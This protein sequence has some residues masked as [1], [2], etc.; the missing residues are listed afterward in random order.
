MFVR[1]EDVP[2]M[3]QQATP[4]STTP[5]MSDVRHVMRVAKLHARA[6]PHKPNASSQHSNAATCADPTLLPH[7]HAHLQHFPA[8]AAVAAASPILLALH[9]TCSITRSGLADVSFGV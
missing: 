7:T 4:L 3:P 5:L 8:T 2:A 6:A 1:G 9:G